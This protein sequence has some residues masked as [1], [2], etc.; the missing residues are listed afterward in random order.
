M[1]A[2]NLHTLD[3]VLQLHPQSGGCCGKEVGHSQHQLTR[4]FDQE[5]ESKELYT[6]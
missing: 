2:N 1:Q 5:Q 4:H 6:L 3:A